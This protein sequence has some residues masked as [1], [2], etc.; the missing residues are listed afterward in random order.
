MNRGVQLCGLVLVVC[1]A[2]MAFAQTTQVNLTGVV[3]QSY[4]GIYIS[5]Y[6]ATV[7]GATNTPIICDDFADESKLPSTW[8]ATA[9]SFSSISSSPANTSWALAGNSMTLPGPLGQLYGEVGYF[10]TLLLSPSIQ[11]TTNQ[12]IYTSAMWAVFDPTGVEQW[13]TSG[14]HG[15]T[16]GISTGDLCTAIFG[17]EGCAWKVGDTLGGQLATAYAASASG[18]YSNLVVLSPNNSNGTICAAEHGCAAQEFIYVSV[19][20]GGTAAAYL[21]LSGFCCLGAIFLRSRRRLAPR[22]LA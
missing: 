17:T 22:M 8:T 21:L 14:S 15:S 9:T 3:G 11:G 7:G 10:A 4:D 13:L 12:I 2:P 18:Q 16:S 19:P 20:D 6:Y 1:L 5:P